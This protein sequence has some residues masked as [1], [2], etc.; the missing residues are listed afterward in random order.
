M[1]GVDPAKLLALRTPPQVEL[2]PELEAG[3]AVA[4]AAPV[5]V[6][7]QEIKAGRCEH[8]ERGVTGCEQG[9]GAHRGGSS[10]R[11]WLTAAGVSGA[12][13]VISV[14]RISSG[15]SR[16]VPLTR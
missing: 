4:A 12:G 2:G 5:R 3:G 1:V 16:V 15:S 6:A 11:I 8:Q 9:L 10:A 13:A 14:N 7:R